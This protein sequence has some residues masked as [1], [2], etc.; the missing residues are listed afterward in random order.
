MI[1]RVLFIALMSLLFLFPGE[2][3]AQRRFRAAAVGGF[4]LAQLDGDKLG[5]YNQ[6]GLTGG[7]Q[8]YT[9]LTDRWELSLSMLYSQQGSHR[10][11]TD[12]PSSIYESI[13]LNFVEAPVMIH[14]RD[15][16]FQVGAGI[17]YSNLINYKVLDY[18][19]EDITDR[20]DYDSSIFS[21]IFGVTLHLSEHFGIDVRW[22]KSL[23]NMQADKG[24]GT[25]IGRVIGIRGVYSF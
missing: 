20:Q 24:D 9:I 21:L 13:R 18:T 16:K 4:N 10:T 6:I 12:D 14:F 5:G 17:S 8:V 23:N 25:L 7:M 15:W 1:F 11:R 22:H 19:G 2:A 3:T